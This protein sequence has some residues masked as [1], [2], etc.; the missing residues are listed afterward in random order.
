M[1]I[2]SRL[3]TGKMD[4]QSPSVFEGKKEIPVEIKAEAYEKVRA[5]CRSS[6]S[7]SLNSSCPVE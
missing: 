6:A 4:V 1:K 2:I 3:R 5:L 7:V